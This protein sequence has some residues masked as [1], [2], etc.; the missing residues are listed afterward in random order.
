MILIPFF[1]IF[2]ILFLY[3]CVCVSQ[4]VYMIFLLSR[5]LLRLLGS[6][7]IGEGRQTQATFQRY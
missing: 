5:L 2:L 7:A 1:A 3:V 4:F 6:V